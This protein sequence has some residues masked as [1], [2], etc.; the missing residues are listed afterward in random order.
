M[1]LTLQTNWWNLTRFYSP[2]RENARARRGK[3]RPTAQSRHEAR[4]CERRGP[5]TFSRPD[6]QW[7]DTTS[8]RRSAI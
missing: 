6:G 8:R 3:S 5:G 7:H 2:E 4:G 1:I